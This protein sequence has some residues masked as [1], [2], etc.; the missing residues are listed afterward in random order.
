MKP[1]KKDI[2]NLALALVKA[3]A[4]ASLKAL[5]EDGGTS[6]FDDPYII[7]KGWKENQVKE[8]CELAKLRLYKL[9][10]STYEIFGATE[11]QGFRRTAMAE[12]FAQSLKSQ[13]YISGVYYVID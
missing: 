6:N 3:R 10:G 9:C 2:Q 5:T 1:T 12:A 4:E 13:G 11:G 7:L 8:A